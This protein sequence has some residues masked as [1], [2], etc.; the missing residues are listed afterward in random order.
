MLCKPQT[1]R[2]TAHLHCWFW[3]LHHSAPP[4]QNA[5]Q[6]HCVTPVLVRTLVWCPL[7]QLP[8]PIYTVQKELS[9]NLLCLFVL[10][11]LSSVAEWFIHNK[12]LSFFGHFVTV[13]NS[14]YL[15]PSHYKLVHSYFWKTN[16]LKFY[17]DSITVKT[18]LISSIIPIT[19][20]Q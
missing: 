11:S 6:R 1:V 18:I 12:L 20:Y 14:L 19:R 16:W 13:L 3:W 5:F 4:F 15:S 9:I 2:F 17:S 10:C 8:C 7:L